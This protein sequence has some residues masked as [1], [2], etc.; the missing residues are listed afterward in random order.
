[1]SLSED[2]YKLMW[3]HH[4]SEEHHFP[5]K[6]NYDKKKVDKKTCPGRR[7]ACSLVFKLITCCLL[8]TSLHFC[9]KMLNYLKYHRFKIIRTCRL[10][11]KERRLKVTSMLS[12]WGKNSWYSGKFSLTNIRLKYN[13]TYIGLLVFNNNAF[14]VQVNVISNN[15][16]K[17]QNH[18]I[19]SHM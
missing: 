4:S 17:M 18:E 7:L 2:E 14:N 16:S 8:K 6:L 11:L 15:V 13:I 1:M 10:F 9:V 19:S 5:I 12:T 3:S